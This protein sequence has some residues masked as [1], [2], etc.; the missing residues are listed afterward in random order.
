[1][2][3]VQGSEV[4]L[5]ISLGIF[6][7][8]FIAVIVVLIFMRKEHVKHMSELPLNDDDTNDNDTYEKNS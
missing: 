4:Y 7:L 6:I 8:F 3:N 1:M 5:L 2:K